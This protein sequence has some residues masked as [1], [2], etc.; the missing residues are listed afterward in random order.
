MLA[1][2]VLIP[3]VACNYPGLATRLPTQVSAEELRQTLAAAG[4]ASP[5]TMEPPAATGQSAEQTSGPPVVQ[6][7]PMPSQPPA[8]PEIPAG[9]Y[10]TRP[11]D[12]PQALAARYDLEPGELILPT[13]QGWQDFIPAGTILSIP[14]RLE[15]T[16]PSQLLLPDSEL[17]YSP[18]ALHFDLPSFIHAAG[19]YLSSYTEMVDE[20][21]MSGAEII[22]RA[23]DELSVNPRLLLGLLEFRSGWVYGEPV[24]PETLEHPIGFYVPGRSGLYQEITI[25]A[26]QLNVGY[27]GWRQGSKTQVQYR[28]GRAQRLG[29]SLNAGSAALQH[30]FALLYREEDWSE[31]LYGPEGFAS[32]YPKHFGDPWAAA[33]AVGPLFPDGLAQPMLE[34]PFTPGERWSLTAGPHQTWN[35]GTPRGAMD[36]SPVTGEAVCA[37]SRAWVTASAAG[38]IVRSADNAVV[39]DLDGDGYE[40]TGWVLLYYHLAGDDTVRAG[41]FVQTDHPL[42]H[43]SCEGG[44]ATGKHV[45][46]ARKFNGEWL[47]ATGALPMILS[48]W[49]AQAD[50]RNYYGSL[51]KGDQVVSSNSSGTRTSII[52]R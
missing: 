13:S 25:A 28:Q 17:V 46:L 52:I 15:G 42:G 6:A 16:T 38:I 3:A 22:Q 36:F 39:L 43:P 29:P 24:N 23:A 20:R 31:A 11:G 49:T 50:E 32:Q 1:L 47:P 44:R 2:I 34:L 18:A 35:A 41:T 14:N 48:G 40:Q 37:V 33:Q 26:T 5:A 27:Y 19:G 12:T 4:V 8:P 45:H 9:A 7:S 21:Q 10:Q 51:V 30:L